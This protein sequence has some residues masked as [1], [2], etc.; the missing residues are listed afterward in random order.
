MRPVIRVPLGLGPSRW[1]SDQA[2]NLHGNPTADAKA[3]WTSRRK[4]MNTNGITA[5]LHL[6]AGDRTRCMYCGDSQGCDIEHFRPKAVSQ[7]RTFVFSW[8]NLLWICQPC[9]RHK[10]DAFP[11]DAIDGSPL[12]LDPASDKPWDYFDFVRETGYLV[13]R[14][15]IVGLARRRAEAT[16]SESITRISFQIILDERKRASRQLTRATAAFLNGERTPHAEQE[17]FV[18]CVDAGYPEL[19]EWFYS[20]RGVLESPFNQI[21]HEMPDVVAKLRQVMN[22]F[23]P[24]VW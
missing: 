14:D 5:A 17:F 6:M 2:E 18:A 19:C 8:S 21:L 24:G 16:V 13:V 4:T 10:G 11:L 22:F 20:E 7:W 1:L 12:L 23:F 3:R 9:N 15:D